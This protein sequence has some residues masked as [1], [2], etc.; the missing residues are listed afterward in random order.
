MK[1]HFERGKTSKIIV[2][3]LATSYH[4]QKTYSVKGID[5]LHLRENNVYR[6]VLKLL[7]FHEYATVGDATGVIRKRE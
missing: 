5:L 2:H 3:F 7:L 4:K 6:D 1:F